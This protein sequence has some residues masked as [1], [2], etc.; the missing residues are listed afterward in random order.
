MA[1]G[2]VHFLDYSADTVLPALATRASKEPATL[3]D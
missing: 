3:E 1:G 2:N